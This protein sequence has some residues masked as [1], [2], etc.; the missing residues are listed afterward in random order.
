[1]DNPFIEFGETQRGKEQLIVNEK[2]LY[3]FSHENKDKKINQNF[4]DAQNIKTKFHCNSTITLNE[5]NSFLK[6][7]ES[8]NHP[9]KNLMHLN[10]N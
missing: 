9:G 7:N 8:H 5:D 10:P 6:S 2:Y 1:M 4:I 3:N